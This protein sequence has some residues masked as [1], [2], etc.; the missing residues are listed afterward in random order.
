MARHV[1][2]AR[3][4][5]ALRKAQLASA[6]KRKNRRRK[7]IAGGVLASIGYLIG[8]EITGTYTYRKNK[9]KI[10]NIR[11][12]RLVGYRNAK[13]S[14]REYRAIKHADAME[15]GYDNP[16]SKIGLDRKVRVPVYRRQ[17]RTRQN[18]KDVFESINSL[19]AGKRSTFA[20]RRD[21]RQA[22]RDAKPKNF[23]KDF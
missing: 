4:K 18:R 11:T 14:K 22:K 13:I 10:K 20:S 5:A 6:R 8:R 2:T 15:A 19:Y 7:I 12:K 3:R 16:S 9:S 1:M 23:Y 21:Y 17:F